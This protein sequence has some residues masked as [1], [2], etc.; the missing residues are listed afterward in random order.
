MVCVISVTYQYELFF[1]S[2]WKIACFVV[3]YVMISDSL[4]HNI[5]NDSEEYFEVHSP[6]YEGEPLLHRDWLICELLF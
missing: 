5:L 6:T 3:N 4:S 1:N 2:I